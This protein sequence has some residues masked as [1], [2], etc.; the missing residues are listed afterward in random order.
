MKAIFLSLIVLCAGLA[1]CKKNA[2]IVSKD[3]LFSIEFS[4]AEFEQ[5]DMLYIESSVDN[6]IAFKTIGDIKAD[7][8]STNYSFDVTIPSGQ[9]MQY[10]IK[11]VTKTGDIY[12]PIVSN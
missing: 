2:D 8:A 7:K 9:K 5:D 3:Q 12:S 11:A 1:S 6:G 4:I 10:R